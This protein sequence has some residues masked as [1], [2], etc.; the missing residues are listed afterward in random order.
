MPTL[1]ID[2]HLKD[3]DAWVQLFAENPPPQ[4]GRWRV[5]RGIEDPNRAYVIGEIAEDEVDAV[6]AHIG[7][8]E[9][10]RVFEEVNAASTA[11]LEF[12][13]L[14]DAAPS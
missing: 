7:S 13:W 3:F 6:K 8:P 12:V 9:M 5:I 10:Q 1:V 11:P 2:H 4:H 14:E